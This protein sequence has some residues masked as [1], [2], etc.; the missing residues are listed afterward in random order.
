VSAE[1]AWVASCLI[2]CRTIRVFVYK[3]VQVTLAELLLLGDFEMVGSINSRC[4]NCS[5]SWSSNDNLIEFVAIAEIVQARG[6][7][8]DLQVK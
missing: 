3:K 5:V 8:E 7:F 4:G 1:Y 6:E 2:V